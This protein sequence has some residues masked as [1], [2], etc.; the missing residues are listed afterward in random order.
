MRCRFR[1][2]FAVIIFFY[3]PVCIYYAIVQLVE[4]IIR[5]VVQVV[6]I[7][8]IAGGAYSQTHHQ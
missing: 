7:F 8:S 2:L 6:R 1:D 4:T 5:P 3:H